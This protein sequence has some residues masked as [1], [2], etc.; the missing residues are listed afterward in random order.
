MDFKNVHYDPCG[1]AE[2]RKM[3]PIE[4]ETTNVCAGNVAEHLGKLVRCMEIY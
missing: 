4:Q 3:S 2:N 1:R